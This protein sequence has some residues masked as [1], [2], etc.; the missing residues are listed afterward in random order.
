MKAWLPGT[1]S[2]EPRRLICRSEGQ[3]ESWKGSFWGVRRLGESLQLQD[4][5][6]CICKDSLLQGQQPNAHKVS[7]KGKCGC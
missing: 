3:R 2:D 1:S 6:L 7:T 5:G 4:I